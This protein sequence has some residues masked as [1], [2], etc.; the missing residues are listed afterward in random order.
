MQLARVV[1]WRGASHILVQYSTTF[2][3]LSTEAEFMS[4][5]V[6]VELFY[7]QNEAEI[8]PHRN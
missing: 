6:N 2:S 1:R 5:K 7:D 8:A 3:D 4:T